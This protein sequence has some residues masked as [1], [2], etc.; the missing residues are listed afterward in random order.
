MTSHTK[1]DTEVLSQ[2]AVTLADLANFELSICGRIRIYPR[3]PSQSIVIA[4]GGG[5]DTY[6][7]WTEIIAA[8]AIP[9][10]FTLFGVMI[11]SLSATGV[12]MLQFGDCEA[13]STPL[14]SE[15]QGELRF[16]GTAPIGRSTE[17]ICFDCRGIDANRRFMTRVKNDSGGDNITISVAVRK[18]LEVSREVEASPT[19]PW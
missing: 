4:T 10:M 13:G 11:E 3:E 14:D 18:Y 12:Y 6:G 15:I 7:A 9:E 19:W 16:V 8:G 1:K 17:I 2:I 5:A